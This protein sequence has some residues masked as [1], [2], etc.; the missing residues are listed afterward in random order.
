MK[1]FIK[2]F[3]KRGMAFAWMGPIILCIVW[4]FLN[5]TGTVTELSIPEI[6][7]NVTTITFMA[8]IAAGISAVYTVEKLPYATAGLI[9]MAVLY[10]DYM[11]IY[12][13]NGWMPVSAVPV[14]SLIFFAGFLIVWV[15]IYYSIKHVTDR[16]NTKLK[17]SPE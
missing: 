2:E 1:N 3:C 6:I 14:F 12:L 11:L 17:K 7:K 5:E 4:Y 10:F 13:L 15:I 9:Q 8:F 16:M